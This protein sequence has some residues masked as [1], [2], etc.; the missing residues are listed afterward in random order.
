ME[1]LFNMLG[2]GMLISGVM[3][4]TAPNPGYSVFW[5]I[6]V[7][8]SGVG[9]FVLLEVEYIGLIYLIVYV[10]AIAIFFLFVIMM[11]KLTDIGR[12]GYQLVG[13]ILGVVFF[14]EVVVLGDL[15]LFGGH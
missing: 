13:F 3:V 9:L 7:F 5:L 8:T 14:F 2:A 6:T 12:G 11:L 15:G 1:W 4:I 10:G